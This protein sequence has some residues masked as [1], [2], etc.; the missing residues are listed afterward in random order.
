MMQVLDK[1]LTVKVIFITFLKLCTS[2][3]TAYL[4]NHESKTWSLDLDHVQ[5]VLYSNRCTVE[6]PIVDSA[7]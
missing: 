2:N 4:Y 3:A 1:R 5:C 7:I 6:R